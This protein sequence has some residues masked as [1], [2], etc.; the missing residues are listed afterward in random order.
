MMKT[1]RFQDPLA[2]D[3][4]TSG[5][6]RVAGGP[7]SPL[8]QLPAFG[9]AD[10]SGWIDTPPFLG[11]DGRGVPLV[12]R[13]VPGTAYRLE[14]S[15]DLKTWTPAGVSPDYPAIGDTTTATYYPPSPIP[16]HLW[17]RVR[18]LQIP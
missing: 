6:R 11:N 3:A 13:S 12:W 1:V 15:T 18:T 2:P 5:S 8:A 10:Q 16:Q 4:V 9:S 17:L 7:P 14:R